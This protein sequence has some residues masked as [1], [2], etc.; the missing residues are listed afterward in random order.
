MSDVKK[1]DD[2][3]EI[4]VYRHPNA[5]IRSYL[6][7]E[8]ISNPVVESFRAPYTPEKTKSLPSLGA[9]GRQIVQEIMTLQGI[10]EIRVK[11]KEIRII[12]APEASWDRIE[13]PIL[14]LLASALKRKRL[15]RVK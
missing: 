11:P 12:K 4:E 1:I 13:G 6:T 2:G 3:P 5:E 14:R 15:R 9:L 8:P 10:T 7:Q